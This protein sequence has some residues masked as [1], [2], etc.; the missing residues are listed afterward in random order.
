MDNICRGDSCMDFKK[1]F[2]RKKTDGISL[3]TKAKNILGDSADVIFSDFHIGANGKVKMTLL[4][5]DGLVDTNLINDFIL[6]PLITGE[7]F[8]YLDNSRD[9]VNLIEEGRL[10]FASHKVVYTTEDCLAEVMMGNVAII[11]DNVNTAIT[12]DVKGFDKR[13]ITEPSG[14]NVLKGAKD[15]FIEVLR[16]NTALVRRKISTP[17]LKVKQVVVGEQTIT[18]I[19]IIYIDGITNANL[20]DEVIKRIEGLEIDEVV[21]IGYIEEYI[22]DNKITAF[23]LLASTERTDKFCANIISGRVGVLIDGLPMGIV[24]PGVLNQFLQAPEDYAQNYLVSSIIRL[25]RYFL[26]FLTLLLPGFYVSVVTFHQEMIPTDLALSIASSKQGVPFP[27]FVEVLLMLIAFEI[28]LEA[29]LRLPKNIGDAVSI[30]GAL[31]VGEAAVS[32]RIVSP[33][34][35]IVVALTALATFTM[36]NQDL[37]N[38]LR[39]WRFVLTIFSS[40]AGLVGLAIGSLLLLLHLCTIETFGI[41]YLI[42]FVSHEGREYADTIFRL[43]LYLNKYRPDELKVKNKRKQR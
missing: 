15:T 30:V 24:I 28:L 1:L 37:S 41:P 27:S 23:P 42:P 31:I 35:V 21:T 14:E 29:G 43:P 5:I 17:N 2:K 4:Y 11:F 20:V 19:A 6:K 8:N 13:S 32:A 38:A 22:I 26:M 36:P 10:Y 18:H 34:I 12:F 9:I 3:T 39:L 25:M 7:Q 16:T 33:G 40:I